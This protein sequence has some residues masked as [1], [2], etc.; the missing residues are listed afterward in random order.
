MPVYESSSFDPPFFFRNNYLQTIFP[1]L[2]RKVHG[3][4]YRRQ[5]LELPDGDFVD[6]D[7][8]K[9]G[10]TK[11]VI[12]LHG[13]EG[14]AQRP[15]IKAPIRLFN[16]HGWD[17]VGVNFRG[18]S[19]Q[20]NRKLKSYHSGETNDLR[21]ILQSVLKAGKYSEIALVGFS[22]GGNVILKYLGEEN[23]SVSEKI[24]S[25]VVFSVPC[26]LTTA[27][28]ELA[29][30]KN[31][32]FMNRFMDSLKTKVREKER[33]ITPEIDLRKVYN[34]RNFED[35]DNAFTAPVNGF[36]DAPDYW[37]KSSSKPYLDKIKIPYL[38][39]NASDDS[40]LSEECYPFDIAA[41]NPMCHLEVPEFGG[42]VG[43]V[44]PDENGFYWSEKRAL[45]FIFNRC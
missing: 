7:W 31:V 6:L 35:F 2:L 19:G 27:S 5:R 24:K 22:L 14:S 36:A 30:W 23:D 21:Y 11:L 42:H 45:D 33:L 29:K 15:Y 41:K 34:S 39:V 43:F 28:I 38:I 4:Q 37:E 18:C 32:I 1:A 44:S 16:L 25:A 40:F 10:S 12:A 13:L 20:P 3:I 9:I 26:D 17:G 8:S